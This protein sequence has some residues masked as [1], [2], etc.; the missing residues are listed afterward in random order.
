MSVHV[1]VIGIAALE[2][3]PDGNSFP[4][5]AKTLKE[6]FRILKQGGVLTITSITPEQFEANWFSH[7][8][9]Q[10]IQRWQKR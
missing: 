9:P 2:Q 1:N 4:T 10:N 8:I 6:V 5:V 3:D 7:L